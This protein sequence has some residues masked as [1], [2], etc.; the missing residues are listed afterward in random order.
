MQPIGLLLIRRLQHNHIF[1]L[2]VRC[3][4]DFKKDDVEVKM[5]YIIENKRLFESNLWPPVIITPLAHTHTHT[6]KSSFDSH[7]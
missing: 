4:E 3:E 7:R 1:S 2:Y 6:H 5:T